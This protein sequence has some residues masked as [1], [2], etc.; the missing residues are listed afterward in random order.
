MKIEN[1]IQN[2]QEGGKGKNKKRTKRKIE[3]KMRKERKK[4][5][6]KI[7]AEIKNVRI[8]EVNYEPLIKPLAY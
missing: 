2:K 5:W 8:K 3:V 4:W 6:K 7:K 1:N